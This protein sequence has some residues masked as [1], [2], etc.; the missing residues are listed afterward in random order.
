[1]VELEEF[2]INYQPWFSIK[3]QALANFL[4]E[5]TIEETE[6]NL[7]LVEPELVDFWTLYFN[8]S[9]NTNKSGDVLILTN[10]DNIMVKQYALCFGFKASNDEP[11]Y[12]ALLIGL[13]IT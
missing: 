1:M 4:M 12:E 3:V 8:G 9:S 7:E 6:V 2:D 11:E 5:C 13:K 10:P